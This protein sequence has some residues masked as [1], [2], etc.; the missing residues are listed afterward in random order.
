MVYNKYSEIYYSV[1]VV[2]VYAI[3]IAN[4]FYAAV[5]TNK[6]VTESKPSRNTDQT[7]LSNAS[8]ALLVI[9][10]LAFLIELGKFLLSRT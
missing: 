2:V 8:T 10:L 3:A 4:Y 5:Y 1:L 9:T 7:R 6:D